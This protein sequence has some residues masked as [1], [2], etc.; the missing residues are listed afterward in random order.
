MRYNDFS[1]MGK[2]GKATSLNGRKKRQTDPQKG[3]RMREAIT[4]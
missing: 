1:F 3:G 4:E 2:Q